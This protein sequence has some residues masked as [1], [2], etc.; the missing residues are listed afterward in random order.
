[1]NRNNGN[2]RK[3]PFGNNRRNYNRRNRYNSNPNTSMNMSKMDHISFL[4]LYVAIFLTISGLLT[5]LASSDLQKRFREKWRN[6]KMSIVLSLLLKML[7]L[8]ILY[9]LCDSG[10]TK[11]AWFIV[12]LPLIMFFF[13]IMAVITALASIRR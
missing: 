9:L 5:Y 8:V 3:N 1:M 11:T 7:Y 4:P 12:L 2:Y 6:N 13:L 10:Y